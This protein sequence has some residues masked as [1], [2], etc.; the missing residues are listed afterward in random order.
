[1]KK[2]LPPPSNG[3]DFEDIYLEF[4]KLNYPSS[5][6]QKVGCSG[7]K[8]K[9]VD[10]I[11]PEE[12]IGIQC[13]KKE[14]WN[15][16]KITEQELRKIIDEVKKIEPPLKQLIVTVT[17]KRD[18]NIQEIARLI[19]EK[20]KQ[21]NLFSVRIESWD[22]IQD[23]LLG[24]EVKY[25]DL[26]RHFW[27]EN[28]STSHY[29]LTIRKELVKLNKRITDVQVPHSSVSHKELDIIKNLLNSNKPKTAFQ[30]L[31]KLKEADWHSCSDSVKYRILTNMGCAQ[32]SMGKTD[33]ACNL[34]IEACSYNKGEIYAN[35]NCASAYLLKNNLQ[36]A[37]KY[38]NKAKEINPYDEKV[39]G[40]L[41]HFNSFKEKSVN[42]IIKDLNISDNISKK[43]QVA[44]YLSQA[45]INSSEPEE[46]KK[47]A[48]IAYDNSDKEDHN[49]LSHYASVLLIPI[50]KKLNCFI[51]K[52]AVDKY[53]P[54]ILE[55][56]KICK[57]LISDQK[58]SEIKKIHPEWYINLS[59]AYEFLGDI[60]ESIRFSREAILEDSENVSFKLR[61]VELLLLYKNAVDEG[62]RILEKVKDNPKTPLGSQIILSEAL[63]IKGDYEK[64]D[65]VLNRIINLK[66]VPQNIKIEAIRS[67]IF[68]LSRLKRYEEAE[69]ALQVLK[70]CGPNEVVLT[71]TLESIIKAGKGDIEE[72]KLISLKASAFI[73]GD[74]HLQDIKL[75]AS[76]MYKMELYRECEP[77]F[78]KVISDNYYHPFT[79]YLLDI[80]YK[81]GKN[82]KALKLADI[83]NQKNLYGSYPVGLMSSIY[84]ENG[85]I[86]SA[87]KVCEVF[88]FKNPD[89]AEIQL[90]LSGIYIR[91]EKISEAKDILL[92]NN[93]SI[94]GMNF[95][96]IVT[97]SKSYLQIGEA[98]RAFDILYQF[99]K[100]NKNPDAYMIYMSLF[101]HSVECD[102]SFLEVKKVTKDCY[103][104][105]QMLNNKI[106]EYVLVE[107]PTDSIEVDIHN[108]LAQKLLNKKM[109]DN[110]EVRSSE[111]KI[112][113]EIIDI[114]SKYVYMFHKIGGGLQRTISIGSILSFNFI[115]N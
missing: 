71:L 35:T 12:N 61:L 110:I 67:K 112:S 85:D 57:K 29:E 37:E 94:K 101:M 58:Y 7:Q 55:A 114:K 100:R 62:I 9:G 91:D 106:K 109:G 107:G 86:K 105:L 36:Q 23:H 24:N 30:E 49:I 59:V 46:I 87:I 104:K 82:D 26:L 6:P 32:M 53:K 25:I 56:I 103:V 28:F 2:Q 97:L 64:W 3:A 102:M 79:H 17:C 41:I 115:S 40:V 10:I 84:E 50:Q 70:R 78:E 77:L 88:L 60:D 22:D 72:A 65:D 34:L 83:L 38:I 14:L 44:F 93:F 13:K 108:E 31:K 19:T 113:G 74:T 20:H 42:Q 99:V 92:N 39:Y 75:L 27:P 80:Y 51:V 69:K 90:T 18:A 1:M 33:E 63:F 96:Q 21:E 66:N 52:K 73:T 111:S 16:G 5:N 68:R 95:K 76:E 81:N 98:K 45:A 47:W 43:S 15:K 11:I 54:D 89:N 8:Q 4:C 48:K